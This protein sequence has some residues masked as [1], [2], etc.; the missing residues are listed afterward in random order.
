MR[1]TLHEIRFTSVQHPSRDHNEKDLGLSRPARLILWRSR[2]GCVLSC[3]RGTLTR[4]FIWFVWFV[5]FF[6]L[7]EPNQINQINEINQINQMNQTNQINQITVVVTGASTGIGAACALD[8]V[9]RGMT[10]FAGVRDPRAGEA[11]AAKGGPSLIPITLDVTDEPSIARSLEVVQQVVGKGGL[12]GLV[13]NAG[14]AIGSPLEVISLSLLRTQLEVNVI[15]QIA[16]TQAFLPLLRR[17]RGRIVNMGSIAGRGTI[18]LLGPYSASKFALEALTDALRMELQPW[19]IHVS[20]IEPGAIATPIWEK[21]G[22]MAGELEAL[23]GEEEKV[24]YGEAVMRIREA[25]DQAAQRAIPPEAVVRAVHHALT[26]S[27]PHTRYLVGTDAKLRAW[28]VK[29]LPDRVQDKLLTWAL[30]YPRRG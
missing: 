21:S 13:N 3:G 5:W 22:M 2:G 27:R 23:A 15:G 28:M 4:L 10:V 26:A 14:I 12:G 18:P 20:I 11:L 30:K 7:S 25:I 8:C 1:D 16:V 9:S 29:W 17:G 24:L 6:W 19:G